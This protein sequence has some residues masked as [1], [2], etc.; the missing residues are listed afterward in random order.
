MTTDGPYRDGAV[1]VLSEKCS[2]CVFRPGNLMHLPDGRLEEMVQDTLHAASSITCHQT[3]P[4]GGYE[5]RP[6]VCRGFYDV[7]RGEIQALRMAAAMDMLA[8][9]EPPTNKKGVVA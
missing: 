7:Y 6:A 5:A 3:L 2:T 4:Y 8:Y 1:H 9:D